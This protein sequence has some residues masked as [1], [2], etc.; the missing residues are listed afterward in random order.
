MLEIRS[1]RFKRLWRKSNQPLIHL[2]LDCPI[3]G[4]NDEGIA[5]KKNPTRERSVEING[6][7]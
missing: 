5:K 1:F 4:R 6:Q 3:L 7:T 2:L